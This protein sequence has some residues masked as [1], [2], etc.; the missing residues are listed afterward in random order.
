MRPRRTH[1]SNRTFA[2][3]GGNEDNDLWLYD[4]GHRCV[5]TP[6]RQP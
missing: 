6:P 5:S 2:L 3:P 1:L 4:D